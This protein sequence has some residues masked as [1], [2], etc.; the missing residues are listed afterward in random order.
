LETI[1]L[2]I[3]W[4]RKAKI[5]IWEIKM[6]E[7]KEL[8]QSILSNMNAGYAFHRVV[9]DA[10]G[11]PVD[12]EF[13][14]VNAAFER[15]TG[16]SKT[17]V[18]GRTARE[19]M[20][21]IENDP[22]D[23]IGRF[24]KVA[25]ENDS[26]EFEDYF[27]P[28]KHWYSG[29]VYSPERGT[30]SII[31]TEATRLK[32]MET[33][34]L[35]SEKIIEN[36][37]NVLFKW[38]ATESKP[39]EYVSENVSQF[40]YSAKEFLDGQ[41]LFSDFI[42]FEDLERVSSEVR[43][44]LNRQID[45]YKQQYRVVDKEGRIRWVDDWTIIIRNESENI[46][47]HHGILVDITERKEMEVALRE[48][49]EMYR[50]LVGN[51]GVPIT[52]FTTEGEIMLI[53][54]TAAATFT[55][56]N[57]GDFVGKPVL[58]VMPSMACKIKRRIQ[59]VLES[60]NGRTYEDCY[61]LSDGLHWFSCNFQP[62]RKSSGEIHAIQV[63]ANDITGHK[64]LEQVLKN[65]KINAESASRAKSEFVA[66]MSHEIRTPMNGI[67]GMIEL[68]LA[69][70]LN[71][72]QHEYASAVKKSADSL[73]SV[74]NDI[75]DF[76]KIEARKLELEVLDFD[77]RT[78]LEDAGDLLAL[79][80]HEKD[81]E[82]VCKVEPEV[83]SLLQGDPGRLRQIITNLTSNAV[84]FT[85]K[86]EVIIL[87]SLEKEEKRDVT[88][89]FQV[90]DT[91]IGIPAD[92]LNNLF[93]PFIQAEER[94][95]R[96]FGGTGLGLSISKQLS[97]MMGGQ[98]G[99]ESV[100]G[101]GSTFWFTA[102]F[103]KQPDLK[104]KTMDFAPDEELRNKRILVVDDNR[105]NR[106]VLSNMLA[107]WNCPHLTVSD[108]G[109]A[110]TALHN[111]VNSNI[112]F[113]IA[114]L[115][116]YM[117]GMDGES[118]GRMIK[119]DPLIK[120]TALMMLT[121]VGKRGDASRLAKIGFEAYLT[122]P[123]KRSQFYDCLLA[124]IGR[125]PKTT[126][127]EPSNRNIIT[128]HSVAENRR[129]NT[130]I[131]LVED[132]LINQKLALKIL[133]NL[134]FRIDVAVNGLEAVE[135]VSS[136]PFD[137]ILMDVQMPEMDGLTASRRIRENEEKVAVGHKQEVFHPIPIIAMTAGAM[138]GDREKCLEA[139]MNDYISKPIKVAQLTETIEK[140]LHCV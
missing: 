50:M 91:G 35:I 140:W 109:A 13:L 95:S 113:H 34:T 76:S 62:L 30:F 127:A 118:L 82:L 41:I 23:W 38:R 77:L 101:K 24:G 32:R 104:K 87:V 86:G 99:A 26:F 5:N 90:R 112:P 8:Y 54:N 21:G 18:I 80:A 136:R 107:S 65:A 128:R 106:Q 110:I 57:P 53:N 85:L 67:I 25:L 125:K 137:L 129:H 27:T 115:D 100:E 19:I 103:Q 11:K 66:N 64:R 16:L 68:L 122:K 105:T 83:P 108:A 81:L 44:H 60:E 45:H 72:E 93:D 94:T 48:N 56:G 126:P 3:K 89:C 12:Y 96:L 79:R 43:Y 4:V 6:K 116:M 36:T 22:A 88:L 39:V 111:A 51:A 1:L 123:V 46:T 135:A 63:I 74:I 130:R 98:I 37:P 17:A 75:L 15:L 7:T 124:I 33:E 40:G 131:L 132:N 9:T 59:Q 2:F 133:E 71:P 139:G 61:N 47:H 28:L 55:D 134:G 97:E 14:E 10:S 84:K 138:V 78:M 120:D 102:R 121:S 119:E 31:L 49:E 69:T 114:V 52:L 20:P 29:S 70:D 73:L 42:Y 117:E 92:R 58:E